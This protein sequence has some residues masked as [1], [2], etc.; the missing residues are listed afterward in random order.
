MLILLI[1]IY[2]NGHKIND[3]DKPV[4]IWGVLDSEIWGK[5]LLKIYMKYNILTIC[6]CVRGTADFLRSSLFLVICL[7]G[8]PSYFTNAVISPYFGFVTF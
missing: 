5:T 7:A 1:D 3:K 6:T 8:S 4:N 2:Y